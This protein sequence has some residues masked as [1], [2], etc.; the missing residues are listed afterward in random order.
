MSRRKI[1]FLPGIILVICISWAFAGEEDTPFTRVQDAAKAARAAA[2]AAQSAQ[3]AVQQA[4]QA[5]RDAA[6]QAEEIYYQA[7]LERLDHLR[8]ERLATLP[9]PPA[10]PEGHGD[11][12]NPID[13]FITAKWPDGDDPR[14]CDDTVFI[15]RVFL[16][17]IGVIP[18]ATE[19][20][21]FL[22]NPGPDKRSQL[23]D[24]LL[25]RNEEYAI[26]WTQF[27][28]DALCSNGNH[29]GGVGTRANFKQ[30]IIDSFRENKPYDVFVA[31]L[32]DPDAAKYRGGYVKSETHL[33]SVQTAASVGQVFL[34][35][36][37]K[38]A[39]C[40]DHFLNFEW[41]QKRFLGF[42]S[43]FAP[44]DLQLIRCEVKHDEFL[45]PTFIYD[46]GNSEGKKLDTLEA[47]LSEVTRLI[48]DPADPQFAT[49][50]VNRLWKRYM[51]LGIVE[52]VDDFRMDNPP[53]H[54]ELLH[55][56]AYEFVSHG[57]DIK[58]MVRLI[59]N[60]RTYQLRFDPRLAD[61]FEVG[62]DHSRLFRSPAHRRLTCEQFL[63]SL[64]V[65]LGVSGRRMSYDDLSTGLTRSLGR[66]ETRNEVMTVRS[67]ESAVIQAL[68]FIN[69]EHLNEVLDNADLPGRLV[70]IPSREEALDTAFLS[71]LNRKPTV[72]ERKVS[73]AFLDEGAGRDDWKDLLW[74]LAVSPE[75]QFIR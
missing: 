7:Y 3:N 56:L 25:A 5:A 4:V 10:P 74:G 58:H 38:C 68:E 73:L 36:K 1:A 48:I 32:L 17:A 16:D 45:A 61:R 8:K 14:I 51:G 12:N 26:H 62:M 75:F 63:D 60:S 52:P 11:A 44:K 47:R 13:R 55:W 37:M 46:N 72:E 34:G 23:I 70:G 53:S 19:V 2:E 49:T 71:L 50:F 41:P 33:D 20:E 65:A 21:A 43:Y 35:M 54:P 15:R 9:P 39:S 69:G 30:F 59:L 64:S 40:H 28:E 57:Y 31:Q 66:P 18:C 22:S 24:S 27:W 29:Q 42:A 67:E 6:A